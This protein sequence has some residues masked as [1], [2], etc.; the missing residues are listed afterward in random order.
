MNEGWRV[1]PMNAHGA[2]FRAR[3]PSSNV[4]VISSDYGS[5]PHPHQMAPRDIYG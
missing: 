5:P 1:E 3:E 2:P 4:N